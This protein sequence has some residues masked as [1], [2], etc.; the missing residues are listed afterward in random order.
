[1]KNLIL[2]LLSFVAL[3]LSAQEKIA[4][5][6]ETSKTEHQKLTQGNNAK[7]LA[8]T[9]THKLSKQLELTSKQESKVYTIFLNHFENELKEK[10]EIKTLIKSKNKGNKEEIKQKIAKQKNG[11]NEAL[12]SKLKEVLTAKQLEI[13]QKETSEAL[14]TKQKKLRVK[15]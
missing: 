11:N 8:K 1:M 12:N 6:K 7:T 15:N 5:K 14:K 10:E 4:V 3:N 13:Y 9:E 2:I